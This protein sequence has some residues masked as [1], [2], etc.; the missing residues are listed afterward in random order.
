MM[1]E[2]KLRYTRCGLDNVY[3]LNGFQVVETARGRVTKIEDQKGL[4]LAIGEFLIRQRR[5]LN[6]KELRFLRHELGLSQ[7]KVAMLLGE[8]EQSVARR[9]KREKP[10]KRATPQERMLRYMFRQRLQGNENLEEFLRSLADMDEQE[11]TTVE[12]RKPTQSLWQRAEESDYA[13]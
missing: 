4:H 2:Q 12:F 9:E 3:L 1:D 13:A 11:N 10:W 7:P 5:S 6:G 8:S